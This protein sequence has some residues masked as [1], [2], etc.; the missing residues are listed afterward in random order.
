[1]TSPAAA[2]VSHRAHV[3]MMRQHLQEH[4][5]LQ[6]ALLQGFSGFLARHA[7]ALVGLVLN[8]APSLA[9][10]PQATTALAGP[11]SPASPL[12]P[13]QQHAQHGQQSPLQPR[14]PPASPRQQQLQ[15]LG[16]GAED[17]ASPVSA[18]ELDRLGFLLRSQLGRGGSL[19]LA[20]R[21]EGGSP[22][23]VCCTPFTGR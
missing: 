10:P 5:T 7:Q 2:A 13:Q 9:S 8:P 4:L 20:R 15:Q 3:P 23:D 6:E 17:P 19:E 12:Q 21:L 18:A 14:Q 1:M 11:P 16:A 22:M